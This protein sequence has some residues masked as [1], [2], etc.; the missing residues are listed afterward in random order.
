MGLWAT[1]RLA[2]LGKIPHL[3]KDADFHFSLL[4][5][6][7]FTFP[8]ESP[9][10]T[11]STLMAEATVCRILNPV[12]FSVCRGV[13]AGAARGAAKRSAGQSAVRCRWAAR[14]QPSG[15]AA[16]I[17]TLKAAAPLFSSRGLGGWGCT[18]PNH[19]VGGLVRCRRHGCRD[20]EDVRQRGS[21]AG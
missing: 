15:G 1:S 16:L 12:Q 14:K 9:F 17:R 8:S 7:A 21:A 3:L 4:Q 13:V 6:W 20:V 5:I 18:A 10:T 2:R 19:A 11:P